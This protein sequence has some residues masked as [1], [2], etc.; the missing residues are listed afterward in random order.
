LYP[1]DPFK[2]PITDFFGSVRQTAISSAL[3]NVTLPI[4]IEKQVGRIFK[5][6][7]SSYD[8]LRFSFSKPKTKSSL[9]NK[10]HF[11]DAFP[12]KLFA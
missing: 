9:T 7:N 5:V 6:R 1:K 4:Q 2:V 3:I 12:T 11:P 8:L 10:L